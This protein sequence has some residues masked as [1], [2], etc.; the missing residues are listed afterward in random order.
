MAELGDDAARYHEEVGAVA[1]ARADVVVGVGPLAQ[2]YEPSHWFETA[3]QCV[4]NLPRLLREKDLVLVKGSASSK[5]TA[6][7]TA[8]RNLARE[9]AAAFNG[10]GS[11]TDRSS[12]QTA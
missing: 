5:M 6:V 3:D 7:A 2:H 8:I 4:A 10:S 9:S 1:H 12:S 11:L